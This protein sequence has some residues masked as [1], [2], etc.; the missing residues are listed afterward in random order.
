[1]GSRSPEYPDTAEGEEE[2]SH[3]ETRARYSA[4]KDGRNEKR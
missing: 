4:R 2:D 3:K 1:M